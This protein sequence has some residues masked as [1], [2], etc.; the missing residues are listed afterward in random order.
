MSK[1]KKY[2]SK[3]EDIEIWGNSCQLVDKIYKASSKGKLSKDF[4]LRDHIRKTAISIPS[5]IAEG[6]GR[7]SKK[8]FIKFLYYSKGSLLELKT[9]L[10]IAAKQD[11]LSKEDLASLR[12]KIE[13]LI[14]QT[15]KL[16]GHLKNAD[17]Q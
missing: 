2:F 16:I 12:E 1:D 4:A 7:Q 14:N 11:Y 8:D 5:N 15:G 13:K 6:F 9:Q 10:F 3:L 17:T